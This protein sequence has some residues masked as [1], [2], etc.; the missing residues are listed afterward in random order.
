MDMQ[1]R[2][3]IVDSSLVGY[4]GGQHVREEEHQLDREPQSARERALLL[5]RATLLPGWHPTVS[6]GLVWA[7]RGIII[8]GVLALIASAV[9][10]TLWDWL[11]LLIVPVV[12]AIGGYLFARSENRAA[13]AATEQQ[14]QGAALQAYF[15]TLHELL[16]DRDLRNSERDT[17]VRTVARM[18]TLAVLRRIW[19]DRKRSV[20]EFLYYSELIWKEERRHVEP[21]L[22]EEKPPIISLAR[23]DLNNANLAGMLLARVNFNGTH[24]RDA[25]LRGAQLSVWGGDDTTMAE[26]LQ[27][28]VHPLSPSV[29]YPVLPA[30]LVAADLRNADLSGALLA[31]V[32]FRWANGI[33]PLSRTDQS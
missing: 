1:D 27:R 17:E 21:G 29:M 18:H 14:A 22:I 24:L 10:K 11:D 31:G 16:L 4:D 15:D 25:N 19:P 12:L 26:A 28:G 3:F 9:D 32:D 33:D 5:L 20:L 13:Q 6:Q 8:L 23:A 2:G 30:Y 7:I